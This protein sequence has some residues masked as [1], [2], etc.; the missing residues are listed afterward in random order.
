MSK[1][2]SSYA[3]YHGFWSYDVGVGIFLKYLFE[4]AE[5]AHRPILHGF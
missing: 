2:K 3:D 1:T 5:L 4:G